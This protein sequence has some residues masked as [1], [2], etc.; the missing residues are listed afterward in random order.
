MGLKMKKADAPKRVR[1]KLSFY[2]SM[3]QMLLEL[4]C[5]PYINVGDKEAI[6]EGYRSTMA[7][8]GLLPKKRKPQYLSM[9][10]SLYLSRNDL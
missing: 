10:L 4:D 5:Y 7:A 9:G 1:P 8:L 6:V 2:H 3:S